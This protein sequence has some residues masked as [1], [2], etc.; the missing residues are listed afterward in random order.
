MVRS[1]GSHPGRLSIAN[2]KAAPSL[3][4][5]PVT[6]GILSF[7]HKRMWTLPL[8]QHIETFASS[9]VPYLLCIWG[10]VR[11]W[12][13]QG[14]Q[15]VLRG[16]KQMYQTRRLAAGAELS[17]E[18]LRDLFPA[19]LHSTLASDGH[20]A[21]DVDSRG[22]SGQGDSCQ[23]SGPGSPGRILQVGTWSSSSALLQSGSQL[24]KYCASAA[25]AAAECSTATGSYLAA[26][27]RPD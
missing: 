11:G 17:L 23:R 9:V 20:L 16:K 5:E 22:S 27:L 12:R 8:R 3:Q 10:I 18:Q 6:A 19:G 7:P 25:Q 26:I 13:R 15:V 2:C 21:F 4:V 1:P 24:S 14:V